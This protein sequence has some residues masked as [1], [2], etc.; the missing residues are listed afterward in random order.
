MGL[1][2]LLLEHGSFH[3]PVVPSIKLDLNIVKTNV[4]ENIP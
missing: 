4:D 1:F 2:D 3:S